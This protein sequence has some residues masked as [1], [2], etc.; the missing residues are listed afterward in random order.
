MKTVIGLSQFFKQNTPTIM[1]YI[2]DI[3]MICGFIGGLPAMINMM[4]NEAGLVI[5]IPLIVLKISKI[6]IAVG[7]GLKFAIKFLGQ[8][9]DVVHSNDKNEKPVVDAK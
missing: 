5:A 9:P 6:A 3:S 8:T 4:A 2:G 7:F 1:H